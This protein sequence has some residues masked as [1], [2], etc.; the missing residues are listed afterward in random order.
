VADPAIPTDA[1]LDAFIA[2]RLGMLG[3]DLSVLPV[4]DPNAPVDQASCYET[5]R[6]T[7]RT[8]LWT[9][10][11]VIFSSTGFDA[12]GF[13]LCTLPIGFAPNA[14]GIVLPIATTL[15]GPAFG[16]EK[17]LSVIAA[18]QAVTDFHLRR[19]P[20]PVVGLARAKD[21]FGP[22]VRQTSREVDAEMRD[23]MLA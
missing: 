7:L 2:F 10:C 13:P 23:L 20:D 9:Q 3:I 16:E 17:V 8:G 15:G 21:P 18:Y 19:P 5:M 14:Q 12:L 22:R 6:N 1:E 4:D 11:D